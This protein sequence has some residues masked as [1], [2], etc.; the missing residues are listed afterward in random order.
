MRARWQQLSPEER[1]RFRDMM[2]SRHGCRRDDE[3]SS[4]SQAG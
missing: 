3:A 1:E 4:S 2:G